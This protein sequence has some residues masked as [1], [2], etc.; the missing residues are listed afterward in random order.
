MFGVCFY[1]H[2]NKR[3]QIRRIRRRQRRQQR[4]PRRLK[5][6]ENTESFVQS[7]DLINQQQ[8][9]L[10]GNLVNPLNAPAHLKYPSSLISIFL[11]DHGP[12]RK[13]KVPGVNRRIMRFNLMH[14]SSRNAS[15]F[16]CHTA[17]DTLFLPQLDDQD[18]FIYKK[19]NCPALLLPSNVDIYR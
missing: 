16:L 8:K 18:H 19:M 10:L 2:K 7:I 17:T 4:R 3:Q 9:L 11:F 1:T 12:I 15:L 14:Y 13:R 5:Q 6:Q